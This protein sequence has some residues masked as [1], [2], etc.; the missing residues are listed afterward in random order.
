MNNIIKLIIK[1][2]ISIILSIVF[3]LISLIAITG[4]FYF[5]VQKFF[6]CEFNDLISIPTPIPSQSQSLGCYFATKNFQS[7]FFLVVGLTLLF[8]W[9]LLFR[10]LLGRFIR[11]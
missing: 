6:S 7:L 11:E 5:T 4:V 1:N 3:S 10:K 9:Y 8:V 2:L